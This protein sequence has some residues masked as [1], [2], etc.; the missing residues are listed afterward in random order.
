[1]RARKWLESVNRG[2]LFEVSDGTFNFFLVL[3]KCI[4]HAL[5]TQLNLEAASKNQETVV[6]QV[7]SI[8]DLL[9]QWEMVSVDID[10]DS[11]CEILCDIVKLWLNIR[12]FSLVGSWVEQRK[13]LGNMGSKSGLRK[14]LKNSQK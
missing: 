12:G 14:S 1:M 8:D 5:S 9:F 4:R 13:R 6:K 7:M 3:E 2:G 10:S 11:S